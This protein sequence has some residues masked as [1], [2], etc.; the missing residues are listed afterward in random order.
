MDTR[1][2]GTR[3]P[4]P[5]GQG[6]ARGGAQGFGASQ[7]FGVVASF[8]TVFACASIVSAII[9]LA[10]LQVTLNQT[11]IAVSS[12]VAANL[13]ALF[14]GSIAGP[15]W[16]TWYITILLRQ[17]DMNDKGPSGAL[18]SAEKKKQEEEN[19]ALLPT[20]EDHVEEGIRGT[21]S[22]AQELAREPRNLSFFASLVVVIIVANLLGMVW[23][24]FCAQNFPSRLSQ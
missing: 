2:D 23:G 3:A 10:L 8:P 19:R 1:P 5:L 16:E 21:S 24:S 20:L 14:V 13:T 17:A 15:R 18:F 11:V 22:V 9:I 7:M 12:A 6:T 4:R